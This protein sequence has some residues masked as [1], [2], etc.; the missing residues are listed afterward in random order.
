M[1][2][3]CLYLS[4]RSLSLCSGFSELSL[5]SNIFLCKL[6]STFGT[7]Q[8]FVFWLL[9]SLALNFHL[10][11]FIFY[12]SSESLSF[13]LFKECSYF[14][15]EHSYNSSFKGLSDNSNNCVTWG[16]YLSTVISTC[17]IL[18]WFWFLDGIVFQVASWIVNITLCDSGC[19]LN[20]LGKV[21]LT[22]QLTWVGRYS[23][24]CLHCMGCGSIQLQSL[25]S[26]GVD[27]HAGRKMPANWGQHA[28]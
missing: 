10:L 17:N 27:T 11:L 6:H 5:I 24:P 12:F 9:H 25:W 15:L 13:H 18:R 3:F 19:C 22:G 26:A 20:S 14:F 16:W 23:K 21:C 2:S 8:Y 28:D 1:L 7:R 4:H